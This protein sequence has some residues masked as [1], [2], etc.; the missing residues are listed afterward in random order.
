MVSVSA[1]DD[2]AE[3]R[4][5]DSGNGVATAPPDL[6]RAFEP[7]YS[8]KL[9]GTGLGLPIARRIAKAHGGEIALTREGEGTCAVVRLPLSRA[10]RVGG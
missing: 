5:R 4:V 8:T 9:G 7:L 10:S 3:V 2:W 1:G 6:S